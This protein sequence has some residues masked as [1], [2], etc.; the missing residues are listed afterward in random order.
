V[1][2]L[3][4]VV[5]YPQAPPAAA[6]AH[7]A[8]PVADVRLRHRLQA[9]QRRLKALRRKLYYKQRRV[10]ELLR[11]VRALEAAAKARDIK[12]GRYFTARGGMTLALTRAAGLVAAG[13]VG[14]C[15]RTDAHHTTVTRWE[16]LLAGSLVA[17]ARAARAE[18]EEAALQA[19][20]E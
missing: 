18:C 19:L 16:L 17:A 13:K 7:P 2:Q 8:P 14:M 11:R 9:L 4:G 15:L 6:P 10:Q 3:I 12:P 1:L 5:R 20:G